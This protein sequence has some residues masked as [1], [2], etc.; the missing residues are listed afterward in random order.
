MKMFMK[1]LAMVA[2]LVYAIVTI[3]MWECWAATAT[4]IDTE[5]GYIITGGTEET[6]VA[7]TRIRVRIIAYEAN[8]AN[9]VLK[10][11]SGGTSGEYLYMKATAASSAPNCYMYFGEMGVVFDS[12]TITLAEATDRVYLYE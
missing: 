7:A 8:T 3:P 5:N 10:I 12:M 9:N 4:V 6:T 1:R 2:L 11:R